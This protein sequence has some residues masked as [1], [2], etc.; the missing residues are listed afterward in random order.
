LLSKR[1]RRDIFDHPINL[2]RRHACSGFA[3]VQWVILRRMQ[4]FTRLN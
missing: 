4:F 2:A 1:F 3:F